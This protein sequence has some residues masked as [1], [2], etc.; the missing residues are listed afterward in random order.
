MYCVVW[1]WLRAVRGLTQEE[2]FHRE[3]FW[4]GERTLVQLPHRYGQSIYLENIFWFL[5]AL[6]LI[7]Q[8][9]NLLLGKMVESFIYPAFI[10]MDKLLLLRAYGIYKKWFTPRFIHQLLQDIIGE[11]GGALEQSRCPEGC[12]GSGIG[13]N[14]SLASGN[15]HA[16][17]FDRS[18]R[19][20]KQY[21]VFCGE[22][23][24]PGRFKIFSLLGLYFRTPTVYMVYIWRIF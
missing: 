17:G 10:P 5:A 2:R 4:F 6:F 15:T 24:W 7:F 14:H 18:L 8:G 16:P 23:V 9:R 1:R 21:Y 11:C 22:Y 12:C 13:G 19:S 20:C 3:S